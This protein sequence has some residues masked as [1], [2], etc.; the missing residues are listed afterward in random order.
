[1]G[2]VPGFGHEGVSAMKQLTLADHPVHPQVIA[3]PLGLLPFSAVMDVMYL[4]TGQKRFGH[5]AYYSLVGGYAGGWA[6]AATGVADYLTISPGGPM[7][8][9]ANTHAILNGAVMGLYTLNLALRRRKP[10]GLLPAVLSLVGTAGLIVSQWY[11]GHLV[12]QHGMRVAPAT[13]K[14]QPE[15]KL[16][17]DEAVTR[18][19]NQISHR[20]PAGGPGQEE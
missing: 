20:M 10:S 3:A 14:P 1:M 11:G 12:Y 7:K 9:T 8:Q 17:G 15:A 13:E 18:M 5:A 16:P 2:Q 19:F 6:A 4:A